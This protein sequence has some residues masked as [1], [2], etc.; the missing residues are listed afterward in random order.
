MDETW[1]CLFLQKIIFGSLRLG[2]EIH[3]PKKGMETGNWDLEEV[4]NQIRDLG[5][6]VL[7]NGIYITSL[8]P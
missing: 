2:I 7:G 3:K 4:T 1:I 8:T 6:I 5:K